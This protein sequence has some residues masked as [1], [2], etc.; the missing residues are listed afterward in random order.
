[1][2]YKFKSYDKGLRVF[3]DGSIVAIF[4][5]HKFETDDIKLAGFLA[6]FEQITSLTPVI[7]KDVENELKKEIENRD[8][9]QK[10]FEEKEKKEREEKEKEEKEKVKTVRKKKV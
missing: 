6:T 1:M 10:E 7:D 9:D 5:D 4:A 3:K 8:K 2:L